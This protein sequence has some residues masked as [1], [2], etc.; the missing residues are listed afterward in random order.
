MAINYG[1]ILLIDNN[2]SGVNGDLN[3]GD[4]REQ[5][6]GAIINASSG[7]FRRHPTLSADLAMELDGPVDSRRIG[8]K[9]ANAAYLDGWQ[10]G[11]IN[12]STEDLENVR[13]DVIEAKKTTDNT[14]SLV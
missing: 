3:T 10:V 11:R 13:I 2:I 14:Q 7:N 9:V 12:I 4:A 5:Q 8:R 1:D 6:I